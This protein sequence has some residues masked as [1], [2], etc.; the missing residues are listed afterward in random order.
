MPPE[1]ES[2]SGDYSQLR[3]MMRDLMETQMQTHVA[4]LS[5]KVDD[6]ADEVKEVSS[7]IVGKPMEPETGLAWKVKENSQFI[8][9]IQKLA[10]AAGLSAVTGGG[11]TTVFAY[12]GMS[13]AGEI[14]QENAVAKEAMYHIVR[15][16]ELP[17]DVLKSL[18]P[19]QN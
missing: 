8:S 4:P 10:W 17:E 19:S 11:L 12:K 5:Q 2:Q 9:R 13:S 1:L 16:E 6:L 15:G 18:E 7:R 14:Q 3:V